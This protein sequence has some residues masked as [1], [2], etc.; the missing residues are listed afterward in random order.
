[1]TPYGLLTFVLLGLQALGLVFF[2]KGFFP[3][4]P[5]FHGYAPVDASQSP[6]VFDKVI[7]MLVDALRSDFVYSNESSMHFTQSLIAQGSALPFTARAA[8]PTVTLPRIKGITTGS[9]PNF[10]D[11]VLN[12]AESDNSSSLADQDSW[13]IEFKRRPQSATMV[14]YGDDT[15]LKLFPTLFDRHDGTS[16]FFVSDFTE[17]D[18]NVTRHLDN[19]LGADWDVMILHYLGIDHIGHKGGPQSPFM[20]DK[21]KEM[22]G[23]IE[24]LYNHIESSQESTLLILCGDHGMNAVGNHGGSSAGETATALLFASPA[25]SSIAPGNKVP[26][27]QVGEY[28]YYSKIEQVDIVPTISGLL[29][30]PMPMNNIGVFIPELLKLWTE[31]ERIKVLKSNA[32][33]MSRILWATVD[34]FKAPLQSQ[35]PQTD[36][37]R[38]RVLWSQINAPDFEQSE[39]AISTLYQ[40]LRL[41][42][43]L[44][45]QAASN[46]D[47]TSMI[48]GIGLTVWI[49]TV[50]CKRAL[51]SSDDKVANASLAFVLFCNGLAMFGSS[52]VEE[53]QYI[54][55]WIATGWFTLMFIQGARKRSG[56]A[57]ETAIGFLAV[58]SV[59]RHYHHTGQKYAGS[60][61]IAQGL[62]KSEPALLWTMIVL[63]HLL[64][65]KNLHYYVFADSPPII[66]FV[67][68]FT[69]VFSLF[70]FT[71]SKAL[72]AGQFV[73]FLLHAVTPV[74]TGPEPLR[75]R[76]HAA[77]LSVVIC[78]AF[79]L[80]STAW[81]I[82]K[83]PFKFV[84]GVFH[85][86]EV[87]LIAQTSIVNIPMYLL[88]ETVH[89]LGRRN[90]AK[91]P[92]MTPVSLA[93]TTLLWQQISFFAT[94]NSNS[95]ASIDLSNA[96]N[97]ISSYA[98]VPVGILTFVSNF[99]GPIFFSL[100]GLSQLWIWKSTQS[101]DLTVE[102]L[103][104][105]QY[106]SVFQAYH[107]VSL[108]AV[109]A[110]CTF[111]KTHLFIWTVFSPKLLYALAWF[112]AQNVTVDAVSCL[113][114]LWIAENI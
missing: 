48:T 1:M 32:V 5:V 46:Y 78:L 38:I 103:F 105:K 63:V 53:E 50:T 30:N 34:S 14:M 59:M 36:V 83:N 21:Q 57:C 100:S 76:A 6:A 55:Y 81:T 69:P 47:I 107:T 80:V 45:S 29:G 102:N 75:H 71:V 64:V 60:Y 42:Q 4:K 18:S 91:S 33:Q 112:I 31:M 88:F 35:N 61:D 90:T 82:K 3:Y 40:F 68:A 15:W 79:H 52:M 65:F 17:V 109:M 8:P 70:T 87:L 58:M 108:L 72:E 106:F 19:E 43:D 37:D 44:L 39:S 13:L 93:V 49:A 62:S 99:Y 97:G 95:L 113:C 25:F 20:P 67:C 23:I 114:T 86:I 10:L 28:E 111:F 24:R 41:G 11:A 92:V 9:V 74:S 73:P 26:A 27:D 12:I 16:S 94:G 84:R 101:S 89:S 110:A 7:F 54:W 51:T 98:V 66:R 104:G 85:I 96:Y 2:A 77:F 56:R 22:D